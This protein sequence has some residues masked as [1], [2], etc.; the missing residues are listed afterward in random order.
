[1]RSDH[2]ASNDDHARVIPFR[3]RGT[4]R[5]SHPGRAFVG[6][7]EGDSS[8]IA[9]PVKYERPEIDDEYRHRMTMNAI[10]FVF[11]S[12]LILAGLW[13]TNMMAHV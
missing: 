5:G 11:T 7:F 1:M 9:E 6:R 13:L 4:S 3:P 12:M 2:T 10:A 8:P